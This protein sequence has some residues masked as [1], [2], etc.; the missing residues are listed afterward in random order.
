V[1]G[2][3]VLEYEDAADGV[4]HENPDG[5]GQFARVDLNP[6]VKI[7]SSSDPVKAADLH[8]KVHDLCFIARSVNFPVHAHPVIEVAE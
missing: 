4:M 5:S 1:N 8:H 2:V 6:R 7:A 3:N